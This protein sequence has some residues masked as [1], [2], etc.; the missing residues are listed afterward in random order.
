MSSGWWILLY[1]HSDCEDAAIDILSLSVIRY[2]VLLIRMFIF[3]HRHIRSPL[4]IEK[5][6]WERTYEI[7]A[8]CNWMELW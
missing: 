3:S 2:R 8:N 7:I 5:T 4:R 1:L 6:F